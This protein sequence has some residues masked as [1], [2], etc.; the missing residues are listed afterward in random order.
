[1]NKDDVIKL[2]K[3]T[4]TPGNYS[5][6]EDLYN[7]LLI[8]SYIDCDEFCTSAN[9]DWPNSPAA[10]KIAD[11][12]NRDDIIELIEKICDLDNYSEKEIDDYLE[13]LTCIDPNSSDYIYWS[14]GEPTAEEIADKIIAFRS[15]QSS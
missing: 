12:L 2:I 5:D 14:E 10:Q 7:D 1:M 11:T 13:I 3:K 4:Q 15:A 9:L 6:R 8:L